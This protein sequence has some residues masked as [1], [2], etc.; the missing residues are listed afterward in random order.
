MA[1]RSGH[2][3]GCGVAGGDSV[4]ARERI[5]EAIN[6]LEEVRLE[7]DDEVVDVAMAQAVDHLMV[8]IDYLRVAR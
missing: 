2:A 8:V 6:Q 3:D 5:E 4:T 1:A 7:I